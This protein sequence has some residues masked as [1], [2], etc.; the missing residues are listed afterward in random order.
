MFFT[1]HLYMH[2][3]IYHSANGP[4]DKSLNVI[5]PT[6]HLSPESLKFS[7]WLSEIYIYIS[8]GEIRFSPGLQG[9]RSS[10]LKNIPVFPGKTVDLLPLWI[11]WDFLAGLQRSRPRIIAPFISL[12]EGVPLYLPS[13][14]L[15]NLAWKKGW[16]T[17]FLL[18]KPIFRSYV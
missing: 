5:F 16:E 4:W 15:T 2:I 3:Y 17:T 13:L 6:K 10:L 9:R 11:F 7:H 18:G 14:R 8:T 1:Y 12:G